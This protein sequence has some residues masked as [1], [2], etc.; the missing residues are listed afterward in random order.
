MDHP[1]TRRSFLGTGPSLAAGL[2]V[3]GADRTAL[4]SGAARAEEPRPR[5]EYPRDRPGPGGPVGSPT[6]RGKLVPGVRKPGLPPVPVVTPDLPKLPWTFRD[7]AKEFH[8]IAMPV[9]REFLPHVV[10]DVWGFNGTMP[11]PMIDV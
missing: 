2:G 7:D 3:A 8:L 5:Q 10:I 4:A 6:D 1:S 9:K 11:R